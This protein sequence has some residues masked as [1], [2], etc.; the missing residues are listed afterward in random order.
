VS[1]QEEAKNKD[2]KS[3]KIKTAIIIRKTIAGG[4]DSFRKRFHSLIEDLEDKGYDV[5][6]PPLIR[7]YLAIST[8]KVKFREASP[9]L[10]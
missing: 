4:A 7:A 2:D 10:D 5:G 3:T 6:S 8:G 9:Q 1:K